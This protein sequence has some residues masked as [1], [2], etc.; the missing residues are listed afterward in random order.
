MCHCLVVVSESL[1]RSSVDAVLLLSARYSFSYFFC[2][3]S[4]GGSSEFS[5]AA[6]PANVAVDGGAT[7]EAEDIRAIARLNDDAGIASIENFYFDR[8]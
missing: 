2:P 6:R 3:S 8:H 5:H 1:I 7:G 4:V